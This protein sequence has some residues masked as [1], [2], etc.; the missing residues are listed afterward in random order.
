MQKIQLSLIAVVCSVSTLVAG[1]I[2]ESSL[3]S[4]H[5]FEKTQVKE[6][7]IM[8]VDGWR[9]L[10]DI[11]TGWV[12]YDY[13]NPPKGIDATGKI[14][15][16]N[17]N[18]N[19]G[20][21]DSKGFYIMPKLSLQSPKENR[22]GFK[23]TVVGATDFGINDEKY[24]S[25]TFVFDGT[26]RNSFILLQEAYVKYEDKKNKLLVGREE[27]STPMIDT[28]DW[29]M[30]A[31]SF[32][33]AYYTNSA[34]KYTKMTLGYF[35]KMSGVW[36]SGSNGT[37]FHSM[38]QASF[39]NSADKATIGDKGIYFAA[40]N[41]ND[42][43]ENNLQVWDYY[44]TDMYNTLF[45]QYDY[46]NSL[47]SFN[48]DI[49]V[50]L[51]NFREVGYLATSV[52]TTNIDYSLYSAR[53]DG[54]FSSGIDFATG[55]AKYTDGEGQSAT[56]GA[57]GGYPYFANGMIFHFF[58]ADSLR[59]SASY[60]AQIGYNFKHLGVK[61]LWMGYRY[62]YFDLDSSYSKNRSG[63]PQHS[64]A[65]NGVR[66]SYGGNYGAYFTGTYEH[67]NLDNEPNT[68]ALRLIGG[69]KF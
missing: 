69:Y 45:V 34:F 13:K 68:F 65:L 16:T 59:N 35:Y 31:N 8:L 47:K 51:M 41:Y 4:D 37:E 5:T 63:K 32:E 58:E 57:F 29:Y 22:I 42:T 3:S 66:L 33:L 62:T 67:V 26:Q 20:H 64:M 21:I 18:T 17:P 53:F 38:S 27:L 10:G 61:N 25:R 1:T 6:Q 39:I 60:K 30:L 52:A 48:Y 40:L 7:G 54:D 50:Q 56:L 2:L 15:P 46:T 23:A 12:Q 14:L 49:G 44:A 19:Q 28:D 24:E 43:K 55:I 11:R 9:I 36:D